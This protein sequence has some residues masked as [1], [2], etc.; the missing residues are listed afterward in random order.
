MTCS[1]DAPTVAFDIP[2]ALEDCAPGAHAAAAICS[3]CLTVTAAES[4]TENPDFHAVSEAFPS[5]EAG[6]AIGLLLGLV[7]SLATNRG[8]IERTL[9]YAERSGVDPL[10]VVDRLLADPSVEPATDLERRRDQL[11]SF[12]Y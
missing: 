3:R 6:A 4:G 1:C 11:E 2:P 12:L 5:G 7:D 8:C 9:E 10:L